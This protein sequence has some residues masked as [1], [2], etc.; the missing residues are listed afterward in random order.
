MRPLKC[1]AEVNQRAIGQDHVCSMVIYNFSDD[2]NPRFEGQESPATCKLQSSTNHCY[3]G[4]PRG[5]QLYYSALMS[6]CCYNSSFKLSSFFYH[7]RFGNQ[8]HHR[9]FLRPHCCCTVLFHTRSDEQR[10]KLRTS[11]LSE[12]LERGAKMPGCR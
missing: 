10:N 5:H 12:F 3:S 4:R 1:K 6:F 9:S 2:I 7:K 8:T 11:I